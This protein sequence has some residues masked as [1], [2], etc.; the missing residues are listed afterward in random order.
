[1]EIEKITY[2]KELCSAFRDAITIQDLKTFSIAFCEFSYG[3]RG[4]T[5]L[6]SGRVFGANSQ[7]DCI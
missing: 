6:I 3:S 7:G 2:L 1:M 5:S 4:D